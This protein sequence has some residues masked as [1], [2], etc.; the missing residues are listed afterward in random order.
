[1]S[2]SLRIGDK[3][4][5]QNGARIGEIVSVTAGIYRVAFN[6]GGGVI[7]FGEFPAER[8]QKV[9]DTPKPAEPQS[10]Q[11]PSLKPKDGDGH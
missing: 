2:G 8:L 10:P 6:H 4:R 9:E 3:A 7:T 5:P 1:M 11:A